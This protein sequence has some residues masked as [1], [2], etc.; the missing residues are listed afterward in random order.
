MGYH[1]DNNA[2]K[3]QSSRAG[4]CH[5]NYLKSKFLNM[6]TSNI[7]VCISVLKTK[8]ILTWELRRNYLANKGMLLSPKKKLIAGNVCIN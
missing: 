6:H 8:N 1:I 2:I 7:H 3:W 5:I 4:I